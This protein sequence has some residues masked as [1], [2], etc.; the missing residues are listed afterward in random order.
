[1]PERFPDT[2]VMDLDGPVTAIIGSIIRGRKVII[3]QGKDIIKGGDKLLVFC[4]REDENQVR[5]FFQNPTRRP[6]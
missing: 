6:G 4:K 3:P 1:V 2:A 5:S